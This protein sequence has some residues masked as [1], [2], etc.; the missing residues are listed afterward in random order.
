MIV[1]DAFGSYD[2]DSMVNNEQILTN[3][4]SRDDNIVSV[5]SGS[6]TFPSLSILVRTGLAVLHFFPEEFDPGYISLG[7]LPQLDPSGTTFFSLELGGHEQELGNRHVVSKDVAVAAAKEF[8]CSRE[9][10]KC[11]DWF[12]L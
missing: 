2:T 1:E 6:G 9:L 10:P 4:M 12:R 7:S 3:V 5:S 11:L 8:I